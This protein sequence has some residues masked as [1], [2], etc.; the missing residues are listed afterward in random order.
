[1]NSEINVWVL[2]LGLL[3]SM[4]MKGTAFRLQFLCFSYLSRLKHFSMKKLLPALAILLLAAFGLFFVTNQEKNQPIGIKMPSGASE[5]NGKL[6]REWQRKRLADPA[7]GEIPAGIQFLERQF[8]ANLPQS[9]VERGGN[10]QWMS[11]GPWNVG[12]RTRALAMDVTNENRLL[13]GGISGGMWLSENGGQSWERKTP[14]NA[15]PGCT[16]ISQDTRPGKT[17]VWYYTSGE[18]FGSSPSAGGAYYLGDGMFKSTDNGNTWAPIGGTDAGSPHSFTTVWQGVWNVVTD[19]SA[20]MNTDEVYAATY[21]AIFRSTNGGTSWTVVRGSASAQPFSYFTDVAVTP[22]G[23]VY[24]T[25]SSDGA[26]KGI[27]RSTN[28]TTWVNITP[29]FMPNEYNRL[30]MGINPD[31]E[32]EV[33]FFGT[34]PGSGH[35]TNYIGSADWTSLFKYTFLG[36][37]GSGLGGQWEDRSA[38]LPSTGTEFDQCAAQGGYDLVVKVQPGTNMVV[39]GGTNLW[40]STDGFAT[41]DNTTKIGGYKVGT[42]LPF[43]ELYPN[44]HPDLH[45]VVFLPSNPNVMLTGSDGGVHRTENCLA[46]EVEW[47]YLN[48]GYITSQFYSAIIDKKT[49]GDNT[50]IGCL[51]D[52]GNFFVNAAEQTAPWV[53]TVNGDGTYG[54]IGPNKSFYVLSIQLGKVAKVDLDADGNVLASRRIDPIGPTED[55]Y[56]FINPLALD[57]SDG[58]ILYL[59]AGNKLYRQNDLSSIALTGAW[60]SISQGWTQFPDTLVGAGQFTAIAVSENA[61]AHRVYVGSSNNKIYR[62]D[63]AHT[64]TPAFT[65][66]TPPVGTPATAYV[67]CLAIDPTNADRVVLVYSNYAI[68]SVF[69]SEDAGASWKKV[70]GNLES[71]VAGTG[72]GPSLRWVSI[73]P[74]DNGSLKYFCATSVG[75][76]SADTLRLHASGQ[77]GT[78]WSLEGTNEIGSTVVDYVDVRRADGLVVAATHGN[79]IFAANF[80]TES[81]NKEPKNAITVNV[82]PNPAQHQAIFR[83]SG[84]S[85]DNTQVR[86]Y[87]LKGNL[88]REAVF[89]G[90]SGSLQVQHLP[91]GVYVW[92]LR[93]KSWRKSGKLVRV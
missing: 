59:P 4:D 44:H 19:P 75:L 2:C 15:H 17:N 63:N 61:P 84:Y 27:W 49:A 24:A 70:G 93:G 54:A 7:T 68:Y 88:V 83:I 81:A 85:F 55:D 69:L 14:L 78:V 77:A 65:T 26:Q 48:D 16:S 36:G 21:G 5:E 13:A 3:G 22:S 64:G 25:L 37:D 52:N 32:N 35:F 91:A 82:S 47:S 45:E 41:P 34:T 62:I 76:Y 90:E 46:A 33:Y 80:G 60:D 53:Q 43:F 66:L 8:A 9:V 74:M 10:G 29:A 57:P 20:P 1:M 31:N 73:L 12:G 18:L 79:G 42:T 38:N 67:N 92:E 58:N 86:L 71:S 6:R 56:L 39:I 40:R 72:A 11:R 89:S 87:D 30:V 23:V 28:G 50:L 51:Q